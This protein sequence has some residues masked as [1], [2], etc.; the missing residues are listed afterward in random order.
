LELEESDD[1]DNNQFVLTSEKF[2]DA[3]DSDEAYEIARGVAQRL[4]GI[5]R[6]YLGAE[7]SPEIKVAHVMRIDEDG[8]KTFA[9]ALAE[10]VQI[11]AFT[12]K[13]D[14][15]AWVKLADDHEEV[16]EAFGLIQKGFSWRNLYAIYEFIQDDIGG[17]ISDEGW[18]SEDKID[19]F[20]ATANSRELIGD[21]ARHGNYGEANHS[22]PMS[23]GEA[24]SLIENIVK[25]W[26]N[27]KSDDNVL[28]DPDTAASLEES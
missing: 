6:I 26:L 16:E 12:S 24:V 22:D 23:H 18:V 4:S 8:E 27:S 5:A 15:N 13:P 7:V 25:K 2:S 11:R 10:P 14:L 19:R 28:V 1:E 3:S 21:E 17:S 20:T 9:K